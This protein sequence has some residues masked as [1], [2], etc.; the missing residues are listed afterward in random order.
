M[1]ATGEGVGAVGGAGVERGLF[2][3]ASAEWWGVGR[4]LRGLLRFLSEDG[5]QRGWGE[6]GA[7]LG[8]LN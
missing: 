2:T 7:P 4:E 6:V 3:F 8:F 5:G 1:G